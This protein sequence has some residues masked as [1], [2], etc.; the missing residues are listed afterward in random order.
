[1]LGL[2]SALD[3]GTMKPA[4]TAAYR[5]ER[6]RPET[7]DVTCLHRGGTAANRNDRD[8]Q[9]APGQG[10]YA[11]RTLKEPCFFDRNFHKGL[12]WYYNRFIYVEP[13]I[14]GEVSPTYF[15]SEQAR[16]RIKAMVPRCRI[17]RTLR[18]PVERVYS[19]YW[20]D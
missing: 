9:R 7:I 15:Y 20:R 10:R 13:R 19:L 6:L 1:M 5:T 2:R 11:C 8:L 3:L 16:D 18:D 12:N 17:I 14:A 4:P